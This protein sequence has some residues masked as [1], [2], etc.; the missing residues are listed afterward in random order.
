MNDLGFNNYEYDKDFRRR[1]YVTDRKTG[2][3]TTYPGQD[4]F[5]KAVVF[6]AAH[7]PMTKGE[8]IT[9]LLKGEILSAGQYLYEYRSS[10]EALLAECS[11]EEIEAEQFLGR[12]R[13]DEGYEHE[14]DYEVL[15]L[16]D[17]DAD[18]TL[19][20]QEM[21]SF[22][23]GEGFKQTNYTEFQLATIQSALKFFGIAANPCE[24]DVCDNGSAYYG[25]TQII[26]PGGLPQAT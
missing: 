24:V 21:P 10:E 2:H 19:T 11:P 17:P 20:P 26:P 1:L 8:V 5:R 16:D 4:E 25:L 3:V 6:L 7:Q 9:Q 22:L 23:D 14:Q 12:M 18:L 15:P 13:R